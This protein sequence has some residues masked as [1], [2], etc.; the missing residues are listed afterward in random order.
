MLP[1][2]LR[3]ERPADCRAV[4]ELTRDAFWNHYAPGCDEHYL[5]HI[6]RKSPDFVPELNYVAV[7]NGQVVGNIMYTKAKIVLDRGGEQEVLCFGPLASAP[8]FQGQGVGGRLVEHTRALARELGY[9]AILILGDPDYYSRFGFVP[10]ERYGIGTS[11]GMYAASLQ[12]FQL[13]PG[14]LADCAG[15]FE[16]SGAFQ[17][18]REDAA[19]FEAGF[20]PKEKQSGLPSQ[21]RFQ[22]IIA[23][24]KPRRPAEK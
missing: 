23:Q 24:T 5:A 17:F 3:P 20:P 10:A 9:A 13:Q 1:I 18:S 15:Y 22:R 6:L 7:H 4:E 16:E 8:S 14:A 21:A 19:A 2:E 11:E 12:A